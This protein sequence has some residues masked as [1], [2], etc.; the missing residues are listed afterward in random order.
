MS[1]SVGDPWVL[2]PPAVFLLLT[3]NLARTLE[4]SE[5]DPDLLVFLL[6]RALSFRPIV[7]VPLSPTAT[8]AQRVDAWQTARKRL[9]TDSSGTDLYAAGLSKLIKILRD[10]RAQAKGSRTPDGPLELIDPTE[11]TRLRVVRVHAV[12]KR[13][14]AIIWYGVRVSA[15]DLLELVQASRPEDDTDELASAANPPSPRLEY[16]GMLEQ[17]VAALGD[18]FHGMSDGAVAHRLIDQH[19]AQT[20]TGRPVPRLPQ[21]R[22]IETQVK[23]IR[24]RGLAAASGSTDRSDA[25]RH[26]TTH[27]GI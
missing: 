14:E 8:E 13:T 16:L 9:A 3:G 17:L 12:D 18:K 15:W 10:G 5:D 1:Q 25:E 20:A 21:R 4:L 22:H 19:R 24:E 6:A 23:K 7:V 2:I 26:A 11:F 27:N